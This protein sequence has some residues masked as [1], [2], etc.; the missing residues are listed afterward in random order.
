[1]DFAGGVVFDRIL[2]AC[3]VAVTVHVVGTFVLLRL[4]LGFLAV[5]PATLAVALAVAALAARATKAQ[6][7]ART[8][9]DSAAAILVT[10][11]AGLM[12]AI[13]MRPGYILPV[14]D[15]IAVPLFAQ[16]V[17][18]GRLPIDVYVPGD[19]GFAY[20][21][22]FPI[23]LAPL[24]GVLD[25]YRVL[26]AFKLVSIGIAAAIPLTWGWMLARL[27][28]SPLPLWQ[29]VSAACFAFLALERT[30][31]FTL[32]FAGKNAQL[33]AGLLA[34]IV[35][36]VMIEQSRRRWGWLLGGVVL[37]GLTL[38]HFAGLHLIA[39]VCAGWCALMLL[40]RGP[41]LGEAASLAGMGLLAS[42]LL[43]VTLHPVIADPRT[44][45]LDYPQLWSGGLS[46]AEALTARTNALLVIF[47]E[48]EGFGIA[49]FPY[50]GPFLLACF[51]IC[52]A[53]PLLL[54]GH[55]SALRPARDAALVGLVG[56]LVSLAFAYGIIPA[57][58]TADYVRWYLWLLQAALIAATLL[59]IMAV[60]RLSIGWTRTAAVIVLGAAAVWGFGTALG[61][62]IR[63]AEWTKSQAVGKLDL[64]AA[65][66]AVSTAALDR[67][68]CHLLGDSVAI[69]EGLVTFQRAKPLEYLE[70]LTPCRFYNGAY[71]HGAAPGS[72]DLDGLPSAAALAALPPDHALVL[73]ARTERQARYAVE[74]APAGFR[75]EPTGA[76]G[77]LGVWR[78]LR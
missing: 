8:A 58:I 17:A 18:T 12:I 4:G 39:A 3:G 52:L 25:A 61:D 23:L 68:E 56:I 7:P 62:A 51:A 15:P 54:P 1:M 32:P 67:R 65:V 14:H 13:P 75:F 16:I 30:L 42:G 59:S 47:S 27:F 45:G 48:S 66:A 46:F 41:T 53:A 5:A 9:H 19:S 70:L 72:R 57:A 31:A 29:H 71:V 38:I 77:D 44:G 2:I 50:R 78:L 60:A 37:F 6:G 73:I 35:M 26:S 49:G 22:G 64:Q 11:I 20:P 10:T 74:V 24:F 28:P 43:L 40:R 36:V 33:L 21:P 34:P 63:Y 69:L 55:A 76:L